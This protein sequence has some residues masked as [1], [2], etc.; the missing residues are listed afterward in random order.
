MLVQSGG[1]IKKSREKERNAQN[2]VMDQL[3]SNL[4]GKMKLKT[5]LKPNLDIFPKFFLRYIPKKGK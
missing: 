5:H 4:G 3:V 1:G 2:L